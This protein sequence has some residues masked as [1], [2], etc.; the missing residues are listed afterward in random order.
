[1]MV[2]NCV[3]SGVTPSF[4]L[5][6]RVMM[7]LTQ[8]A[9]QPGVWYTK[10]DAESVVRLF[11]LTRK[12]GHPPDLTMYNCVIES[13]CRNLDTRQAEYAPLCPAFSVFDVLVVRNCRRA[14]ILQPHRVNRLVASFVY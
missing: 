8:G 5:L 10:T 9:A 13:Y 12:V 6:K 3:A 11:E 2:E 14:P 4:R 7:A 1:M